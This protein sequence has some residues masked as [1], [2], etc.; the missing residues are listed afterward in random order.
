MRD[1]VYK[2][3]NKEWKNTSNMNIVIIGNGSYSNKNG[4]KIDNFDY[5]VRMGS[6]TIK[7]HEVYIGTKTD[8][9]RSSWDRLLKISTDNNI[10]FVNKIGNFTDFLFLEPYFEPYFETI[11]Y[12]YLPHFYKIYDKPRFLQTRFKKVV[13]ER[14]THEIYVKEYLATKNIFYYDIVDR[15][16]LFHEYN[17]AYP[18]NILHMPS[19]GLFTIDF[20]VKKFI[21]CN[22]YVTGFDG[23]MTRYYW[24]HNDEYFDSHSSIKER[25]YFKKLI[26]SGA[27]KKL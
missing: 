20:I 27:V 9:L 21:N 13:N 2:I 22:I 25:L 4:S 8:M 26:N 1:I 23:F 17:N 18:D 5:V 14:I 10:Q 6:C 15:L 3:S 7:G 16:S 12:T 24:R 19:A 11:I